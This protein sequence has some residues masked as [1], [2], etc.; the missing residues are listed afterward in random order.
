M[1]DFVML[2]DF[3]ALLNS[4]LDMD[5]SETTTIEELGVDVDSFVDFL[6]ETYDF[7]ETHLSAMRNSLKPDSILFE[8]HGAYFI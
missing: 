8:V 3:L 1:S 4:K 2:D 5:I 7:S 6:E